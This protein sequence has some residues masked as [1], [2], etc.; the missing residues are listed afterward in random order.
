MCILGVRGVAPMS[1]PRGRVVPASC[2]RPPAQAQRR[3]ELSRFILRIFTHTTLSRC[4][5]D[6]E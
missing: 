3:M 5:E 2:P 6:T 4:V 1:V